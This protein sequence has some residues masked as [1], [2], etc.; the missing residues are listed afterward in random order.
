MVD[1]NVPVRKEGGKTSV[2]IVDIG[3]NLVTTNSN[4][5]SEPELVKNWASGARSCQQGPPWEKIG[6][7]VANL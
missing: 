3:E 6:E 5:I 1:S 4:G 2:A 7:N